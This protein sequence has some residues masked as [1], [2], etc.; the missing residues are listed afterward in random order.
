MMKEG[1][2]RTQLNDRSTVFKSLINTTYDSVTQSRAQLLH[3]QSCLL[4][5][6]PKPIPVGSTKEAR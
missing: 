4:W 2:C 6:R 3:N 1:F 5:M